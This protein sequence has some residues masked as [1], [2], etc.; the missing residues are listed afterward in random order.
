MRDVAGSVGDVIASDGMAENSFELGQR[1]EQADA[2]PEGQVD[3]LRTRHGAAQRIGDRG[4]DGVDVGE[5]AA[6]GAVAVHGDGDAAQRR[7]DERRDDRGIHVAGGLARAEHVEEPEGEHREVVRRPPREC[8]ALGGELAAAVRRERAS[9][10]VL[11]LREDGIAA[12]DARTA[13]DHGVQVAVPSGGFEHHDRA[14]CVGMMRGKRVGD[15]ARHAAEC[16]EVDNGVG[17]HERFVEGVVVENAA[18]GERDVEAVE[19]RPDPVRQVVDD[20]HG[21]DVIRRRGAH[22]T[23]SNR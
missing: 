16:S 5:V 11:V 1:V 13:G 12:V 17:P 8:V 23:D 20:G 7:V 15:A 22:D 14:G 6:L 21:V 10:E 18:F 4:G 19:V 2:A 9:G 3:R